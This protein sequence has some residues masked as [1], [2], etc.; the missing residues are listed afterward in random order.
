[1]FWSNFDAMNSMTSSGTR[2]CSRCAFSC[3]IAIR[4]SRSGGW[5][6]THSPS[7]TVAQT[8]LHARELVGGRSEAITICRSA[9]C[10]ALNVW[11]NSVCVSSRAR[12]EL[13][14]VDEQHVDVAVAPLELIALS[15]ADRLDE[16]RDER[17][18]VTYFTRSPA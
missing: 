14:V 2:S 7:G 18:D 15:F 3:R 9:S 4:V 17:S 13:D 12:E 5:T 1:M 16:L 8:L 6:S 10:R 11:K